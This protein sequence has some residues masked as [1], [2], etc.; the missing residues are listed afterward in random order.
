[1]N[2][3]SLAETLMFKSFPYEHAYAFWLMRKHKIIANTPCESAEPVRLLIKNRTIIVH[4][5]QHSSYSS[6]ELLDSIVEGKMNNRLICSWFDMSCVWPMANCVW[7]LSDQYLHLCVHL[8]MWPDTCTCVC[9]WM[10]PD[11]CVWPVCGLV[12][13]LV[14]ALEPRLHGTFKPVQDPD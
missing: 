10:W 5:L 6:W 4:F 11:T 2:H 14:C 3:G 1:M 12:P 8:D 13:A 9:T 7:M